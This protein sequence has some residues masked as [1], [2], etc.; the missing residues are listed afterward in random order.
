MYKY[1]NGFCYSTWF[2]HFI[3]IFKS[4]TPARQNAVLF[5]SGSSWNAQLVVGVWQFIILSYML[6]L[7]RW[8]ENAVACLSL[9]ILSESRSKCFCSKEKPSKLRASVKVSF[10]LLMLGNDGSCVLRK[11][12]PVRAAQTVLS[13]GMF[14]EENPA[15]PQCI[16]YELNC[17]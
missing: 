9:S 6:E 5:A 13:N 7:R 15:S 4:P 3:V 17:E 12:F 16:H 11:A 1:G 14:S 2:R 8:K 10:T